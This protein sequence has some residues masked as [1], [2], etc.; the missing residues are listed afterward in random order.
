MGNV[1]CLLLAGFW[2]LAL[3]TAGFVAVAATVASLLILLLERKR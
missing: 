1:G 3:L 2:L